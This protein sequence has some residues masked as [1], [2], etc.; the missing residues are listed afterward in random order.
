METAFNGQRLRLAR[1]IRNISS[2]SLATM[3]G[4]SK[5]AVSQYETG[6]A[7]PKPEVL[8]RLVQVL[9]F[10]AK[11][12][13]EGNAYDISPGVAF[14]RATTTTARNTKEIQTHKDILKSYIY[15]FFSN[16]IAF[17][18]SENFERLSLQMTNLTPVK[19]AQVLRQMLSLDNRPIRN[20][21]NVLQNLGIIV[22]TFSASDGHLDA[23]SHCPQIDKEKYLMT[24]YNVT[25]TTLYRLNFTLAHELGHWVLGHIDSDESTQKEMDYYDIE[26]DANDF[27]SEFLLPW[28]SFCKDLNNP[29]ELNCYWSLK[30]KWH[31]SGAMMIRRA[32]SKGY[33]SD[34]IY[35]SLFRQIGKHGW[36]KNEPGD[37]V[38][39]PRPTIFS[40]AVHLLDGNGKG[41]IPRTYLLHALN[42]NCFTGTPKL[43]ED[44]LG[45]PDG[46]LCYEHSSHSRQTLIP[47]PDLKI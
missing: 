23:I 15:R 34:S 36:R 6:K 2:P 27:A 25:G 19:A 44:L 5:Q 11:F 46:Y 26:Q 29:T 37:M 45:L 1:I 35:Q 13:Y 17:P 43:Y 30:S 7:Q 12:F 20:M 40:E 21:I 18:S 31:V 22:T 24:T 9:E 38:A 41:P 47:L 14:C 10:P 3:V 16:Y 32:K 28:N 42:E 33:I 8:F 4:V 39:I